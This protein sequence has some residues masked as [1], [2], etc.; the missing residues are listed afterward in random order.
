[1]NAA[2][3][4]QQ[5]TAD[6]LTW[7]YGELANPSEYAAD[8]FDITKGASQCGVGWDFCAGIGSPRTYAA[9]DPRLRGGGLPRET[10]IISRF[11]P[12][13]PVYPVV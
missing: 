9:S 4:K 6:E 8:F 10:L 1:V 13:T 5:S 11:P 2:A 12:V 3:N 7:I